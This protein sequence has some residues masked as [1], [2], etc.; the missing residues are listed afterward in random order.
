MRGA[1]RAEAATE[2]AA[3]GAGS[4]EDSAE[5]ATT[6]EIEEVDLGDERGE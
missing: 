4:V 3:T 5:E 6:G 2:V 1:T